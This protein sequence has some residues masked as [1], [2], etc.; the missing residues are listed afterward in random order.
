MST[1]S[2][3]DKVGDIIARH[4]ALAFAFEE[5]GLDYCCGGKKSLEAACLDQGL[6]PDEFAA[7]LEQKAAESS[8][9]PLVD[10]AAMSLTELADHIEQTHHAYLRAELPRLDQLTEKV[11]S[12]HGG[13]DARLHDLRETVLAFADELTSHMAKEEHI[14]FPMIRKLDAGTGPLNFHCGSVANPIR[15][16]ELE[17]NDA[18]GGLERMRALTDNF[19]PPEW[20]CNTFRVMVESLARLEFDMHQHVHKEDNVLFPR[21]IARE[22]ELSETVST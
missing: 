3:H 9:W 7:V 5:A 4:P 19:T 13:K 12:V 22:A 21:A 20:A 14:L 2:V 17:H 16:M 8:D 18:G 11:A 10:A 15:Q 1:I 6:N